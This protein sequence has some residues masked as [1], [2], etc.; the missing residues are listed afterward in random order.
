MSCGYKSECA[1][2]RFEKVGHRLHSTQRQHLYYISSIKT[3]GLTEPNTIQHILLYCMYCPHKSLA[4]RIK[5]MPVNKLCP[6]EG[7]I[8]VMHGPHEGSASR[9]IFLG[10]CDDGDH[11][12]GCVDVEAC[13]G[14]ANS[15]W[16]L[17]GLSPRACPSQACPSTFYTPRPFFALILLV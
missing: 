9:G 13:A 17:P 11:G 10:D 16:C 3:F 1:Y 14:C 7:N 15:G 5:G 8:L 12:D 6:E 4:N 2:A